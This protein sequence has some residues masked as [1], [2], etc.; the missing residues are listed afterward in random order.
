MGSAMVCSFVA[1]W[2]LSRVGQAAL[3]TVLE[4]FAGFSN[5]LKLAYKGNNVY[6]YD[7]H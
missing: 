6:S 5:G 2:I 7:R 4:G 3:A 1:S